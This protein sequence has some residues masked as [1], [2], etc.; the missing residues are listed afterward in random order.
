MI[1]TAI[2]SILS[3]NTNVSTLVGT[4]IYP[5]EVPQ[6]ATF[7]AIYF[8]TDQI[9]P[10][11]CRLPSGTFQGAFE[12]GV[13]AKNYDSAI[14][15]LNAI[16]TALDYYDGTA[17]GFSLKIQTGGRE[18]MDDFNDK[19]PAFIKSLEYDVLGEQV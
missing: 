18:G 4:R 10:F 13:L 2:Y 12:V 8:V 11:P 1:A 15:V 16:R 9:K 3:T 14:A 17:G 19:L 7:P 5:N 6:K